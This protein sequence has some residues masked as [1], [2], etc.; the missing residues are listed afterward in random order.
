MLPVSMS[1]LGGKGEIPWDKGAFSPTTPSS[2]GYGHQSGSAFCWVRFVWAGNE[3]D[4]C[5]LGL[6]LVVEGK[7]TEFSCNYM[8]IAM[9]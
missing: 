6:E 1:C 9:H 5:S 7:P 4:G 2:Q 8:Y 3:M